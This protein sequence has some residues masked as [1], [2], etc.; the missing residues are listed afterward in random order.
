MTYVPCDSMY[1]NVL[2][3]ITPVVMYITQI[4][5]M[6]DYVYMYTYLQTNMYSCINV[7]HIHIYIT[8]VIQNI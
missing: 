1:Y 8:L 5:Q 6:Y 3:G 7:I 4:L 2:L